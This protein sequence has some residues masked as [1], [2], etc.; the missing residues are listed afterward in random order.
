M[1]MRFVG[2]EVP[3]KAL[4]VCLALTALTFLTFA[5][6]LDNGFIGIDDPAY[7]TRNDYV[8]RG[9]TREG[10]TWAFTTFSA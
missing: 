10:F 8:L 1:R 2:A 6:V 7:V 9:L 3:V 4:L 5:P